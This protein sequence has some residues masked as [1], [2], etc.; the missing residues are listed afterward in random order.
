[1][2]RVFIGRGKMSI[3]DL[4][5]RIN[6]WVSSNAEW[7]EDSVDHTL[8]ERNTALDGSGATYHAIDV[9]FLDSDAKSN[10]Q[11]KCEDK[12]VNKCD[13]YR[14]GYHNCDHDESDRQGCSWD[15]ERE[16]TAKDQT[17]PSAIPNF[18]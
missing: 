1:M 10:L 6:N 17:I 15:D 8:T 11:Q 13:W 9:R 18:V 14:L 3:N 16:W 4:K 2:F 12:L 5:T 7:T